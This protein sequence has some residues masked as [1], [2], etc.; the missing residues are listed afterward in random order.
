MP[1]WM[2]VEDEIDIHDVIMGMFEIWGISG[3]SFV[4][5]PAAMEWLDEVDNGY[6]TGKLPELALV[7][8]RLPDISGIE[9][10]ARI[11]QRPRLGHIAVIMI[12]AFRLNPTQERQG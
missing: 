10:A 3:Q 6:V 11:R 7:D 2:A 4:T 9:V 8:I 1:I 5:G 12:T